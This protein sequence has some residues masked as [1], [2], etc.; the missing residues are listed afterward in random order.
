MVNNRPT[1]GIS[2]S[3]VSTYVIPI[4][5]IAILTFP[6]STK[7]LDNSDSS[8]LIDQNP[9]ITVPLNGV[10]EHGVVPSPMQYAATL[11]KALECKAKNCEA[12][13]LKNLKDEFDT[14]IQEFY[15]FYL[16]LQGKDL[17]SDDRILNKLKGIQTLET[18]LRNAH[19]DNAASY[20]DKRL[21]TRLNTVCAGISED[22]DSNN[23]LEECWE[24]APT[25]K[26]T[27]MNKSLIDLV[28]TLH[29]PEDRS[30]LLDALSNNNPDVIE[31][32][33]GACNIEIPDSLPLK[34]Q[35]TI[36]ND[37]TMAAAN[38][39]LCGILTS[40][41][42]LNGLTG[43]RTFYA[44]NEQNR[45]SEHTCK[46]VRLAV[47]KSNGEWGPDPDRPTLNY[48]IYQNNSLYRL[49]P[50]DYSILQKA[51]AEYEK[52]KQAENVKSPVILPNNT[53]KVNAENSH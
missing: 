34:T 3:I 44:G 21:K 5:L 30:I 13:V 17:H 2:M 26:K 31:A 37:D 53:T 14:E 36:K 22:E 10:S 51:V 23:E 38:K 6:F 42:V 7:A 45:G 46:G 24:D 1:K 29:D 32:T 49:Q 27:C 20:I 48:V 11:S 52:R 19:Y 41:I 8:L 9:P 40:N 43:K 12:L 16:M 15:A 28:S 39:R 4:T 35:T 18:M 50:Q 25:C 47:D 33:Q